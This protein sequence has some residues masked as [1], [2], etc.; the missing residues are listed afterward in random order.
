MGTNISFLSL[1]PWAP[2]EKKGALLG[3][4]QQRTNTTAVLSRMTLEGMGSALVG[5][6]RCYHF[7]AVF[8]TY[9]ERIL[10]PTLRGD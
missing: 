8:E 9:V 3:G 2:K 6:G 5:G 1:Y 4:A 10:V 7:S